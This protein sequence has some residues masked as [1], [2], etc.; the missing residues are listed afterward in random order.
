MEG[1][2][3]TGGRGGCEVRKKKEMEEG[4]WRIYK[5]RK[6]SQS[7]RKLRKIMVNFGRR[8][9]RQDQCG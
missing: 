3:E 4:K 5:N 6:I 1:R 8:A 7:S 2:R 9:D